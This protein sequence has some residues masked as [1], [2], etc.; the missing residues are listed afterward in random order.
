MFLF[1]FAQEK[2]KGCRVAYQPQQPLN[3]FI[4]TWAPTPTGRRRPLS[5]FSNL[6]MFFNRSTRKYK[7]SY[8][9]IYTCLN[10]HNYYYYSCDVIVHSLSTSFIITIELPID[11][12]L[13][14][15]TPREIDLYLQS[16]TK[17][18]SSSFV[19]LNDDNKQ[20]KTFR[21]NWKYSRTA[22]NL[23]LH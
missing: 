17:S 21:A 8:K 12:V 22:L 13:W 23:E 18:I 19:A 11:I 2:E 5:C 15:Q 16:S 3:V 9:L 4:W 7:E 1:W 14:L 20:N 10:T 6:T